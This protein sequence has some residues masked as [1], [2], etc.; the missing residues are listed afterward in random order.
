MIAKLITIDNIIEYK[1]MSINTDVTKK[2]NTYIQEAQEFDVMK[3]LG[4]EFY[5]A[6]ENDFIA[7]PS[8]PTYSDLFNGSEYIYAGVTYRHRGIKAMLI[9]YAYARYLAN[10]QSNQT[11]FGNVAKTN[12]DS[13]P[14]SDKT[15]QRQ[16]EQALAGAYKYQSD[17]NDYLCRMYSTF[18]YPLWS[19]RVADRIPTSSLKISAVG[20]NRNKVG[21]SYCCKGC[22]RYT[23]CI[24]NL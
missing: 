15:I 17:V 1:P 22:G 6:L 8:L 2:L 24:C 14:V 12:P 23:N 21:S 16:V 19:G 13:T 11:A 4:D 9:Y 10:T 3:F 7:Q 20:G 18:P 5:I